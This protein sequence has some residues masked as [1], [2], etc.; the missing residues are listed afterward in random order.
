[1]EKTRELIE[2][3]NRYNFERRLKSLNYKTPAQY[4][5]EQKDIIIER[6]VI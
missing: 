4:L 1:M 6:I 2:F 5:K 3:I